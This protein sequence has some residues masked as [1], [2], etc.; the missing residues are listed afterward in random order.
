MSLLASIILA[1]SNWLFPVEMP[2]PPVIIHRPAPTEFTIDTVKVGAIA[3]PAIKKS[4]PVQ[5]PVGGTAL[6]AVAIADTTYIEQQEA[7]QLQ[8]VKLGGKI[9]TKNL[10]SNI[11]VHIYEGPNGSGYSIIEHN[12]ETLVTSTTT[13]VR[14][15]IKST[16]YGTE[17]AKR[18]YEY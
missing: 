10:P 3:Q 8:Q 2:V 11:E 17:T 15:H 1:V 16:G 6:G 12:D 4:L 7:K 13:Y 5:K 9:G 14:P 18:T